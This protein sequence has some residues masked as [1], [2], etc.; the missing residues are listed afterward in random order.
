V[1]VTEVSTRSH[2]SVS[3]PAIVQR[4]PDTADLGAL[5]KRDSCHH[6]AEG[7]DATSL[8]QA[9]L[10]ILSIDLQPDSLRDWR[11]RIGLP[12]IGTTRAVEVRSPL[13]AHGVDGWLSPAH[14]SGPAQVSA[15][16]FQGD[17]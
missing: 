6:F 1:P 7:W 11:R 10:I 8:A 2:V 15:R 13:R 3:G 4:P 14:A 17:P 16:F 9:V 5:G 12:R